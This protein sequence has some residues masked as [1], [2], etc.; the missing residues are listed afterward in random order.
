MPIYIYKKLELEDPKLNVMQLLIADRMVKIP[1]GILHDVLLKV[2]SFIF[3]AYFCDF[4]CE[5]DFKFPII[6]G[7]SFLATGR[8][9]VDMAKGHMKFLLNNEKENFNRYIRYFIGLRVRLRYK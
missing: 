6:L 5:L 7:K 4:Y 8:A 2:E 3:P 9:F 1:I